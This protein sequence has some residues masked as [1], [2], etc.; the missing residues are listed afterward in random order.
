[1]I[2]PTSGICPLYPQQ[3]A[4][5]RRKRYGSCPQYLQCDRHGLVTQVFSNPEWAYF[6]LL[7]VHPSI[8]PY[9]VAKLKLREHPPATLLVDLLSRSPPTNH[10]EAIKLFGT[11]A[12][13]MAGICLC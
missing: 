3:L 9:D 10:A 4:W 11:L 2:L 7:V 6:G 5:A 1:M 12:G 13:R 8:Q